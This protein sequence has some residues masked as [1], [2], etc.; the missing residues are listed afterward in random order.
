MP[1]KGFPY[2][3]CWVCN[4]PIIN[5]FGMILADNFARGYLQ[6]AL[7]RHQTPEQLLESNEAGVVNSVTNQYFNQFHRHF[8]PRTGEIVEFPSSIL[9]RIEEMKNH[10]QRLDSVL[11]NPPDKFLFMLG[12]YD[13]LREKGSY[14]I[15]LK[16]I[17][18]F[19]KAIAWT[20]HLAEKNWFNFRGWDI[21]LTSLFGRVQVSA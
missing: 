5:K 21:V 2:S 18:D 20:Q 13:C 7:N 4:Q 17:D 12:H 3:E 10:G 8:H 19:E 15:D 11:A 16:R 6:Y 14:E 9:G 1:T